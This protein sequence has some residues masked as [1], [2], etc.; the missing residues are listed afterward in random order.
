MPVAWVAGYP[1]IGRKKFLS[2]IEP[3]VTPDALS[4]VATAYNF[5]KS[6]HSKQFRDGGKTRY[7][8]H[9]KAVAWIIIDELRITDWKTIA[10]A[11]L[12]DVK[13][14]AYVFTWDNI[15]RN[16]GSDVTIDLKL[17][18]KEPKRGYL[19][20]LKTHGGV[21]ALTVKLSDRLHNL[22]TLGSCSPPKQDR[23][24]AETRE[25][26]LPVAD[27][28]IAKLTRRNR[29]RGEYLKSKIEEICAEYEKKS[30]A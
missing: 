10:L 19:L 12:H 11:L 23:Q 13:E 2:R 1:Q 3:L 30:T 27:L 14:D 25:K 15:Q 20:R 26:Y 8:E 17:V 29:W 18:T 22:R 28:L 9:P 24:L 16:F 5:A 21:R 7:F 6:A 4:R